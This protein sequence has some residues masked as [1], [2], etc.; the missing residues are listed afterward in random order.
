M[1]L[2]GASERPRISQTKIVFGL[3]VMLIGLILLGDRMSWPGFHWNVPLWPWILIAI[4]VSKLSDRPF[5]DRGRLRGRRSAAWLMFIGAW[6][7]LNEYRLFGIHYGDSWPILVIGAGV[8]M[9]WRS[10]DPSSCDRTTFA[11]APK[12]EP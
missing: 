10:V 1:E 3:V 6:G 5:D 4:G 8:F 11:A 7:L 9:V 12:R 2:T